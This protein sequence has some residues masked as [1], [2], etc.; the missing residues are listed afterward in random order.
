MRT[1]GGERVTKK[2]FS[3]ALVIIL[4]M[5]LSACS[6]SNHDQGK[7]KTKPKY[8]WLQAQ[9]IKFN[10][11]RGIGYPGNDHALYVASDHALYIMQDH[12]WLI[13]S[14]NLHDYIGFQAV[15]LGFIA[16]GHPQ[17]G[18]GLKDPLGLVFSDDQGKSLKKEAFYGQKI[19]HFTAASYDGKGLYVISEDPNGGLSLGVNYS[20]DGG[21]SWKKSAFNGFNADSYGMIAVHSLKGNIMA[22]ATRTGIYYSEDNGNTM[23][24]ITDPIMVTALNFLGDEVLFS[25]V[26]SPKIQLKTINPKTGEQASI[27][28]PSL[29][30]DNPIT[31]LS[32]NP[33]NQ[34]QIA[35]TTYKNDLYETT[36][37][38]KNW[39]LLLKDGKKEQE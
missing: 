5:I 34:N 33:K 11:I 38:G 2:R 18:T 14:T 24:R 35:F 7:A 21:K 4:I 29:D 23:K 37:G 30:Y 26:E 27:A 32:V 13:P 25:S 3:L 6:G 31:Y 1:P 22:M 9:T 8:K 12:K 10:Q 39:T 36:D 15:K 20:E 28:I 16:S 17:K 19:F